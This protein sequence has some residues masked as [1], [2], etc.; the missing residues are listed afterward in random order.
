MIVI[1]LLVKASVLFAAAA[2]LQWTAA[3]RASAA[4]RHLIYTM[5]IAGVLLLPALAA[6]LPSWTALELRRATVPR[7]TQT[8]TL[9]LPR[10][11]DAVEAAPAALSGAS[12]ADPSINPPG[13]PA[14]SGPTVTFA[15]YVVVMV[16]LL[17]RL[18][19][20]R[21]SM[22]RV[23]R[24]ATIVCDAEWVHG[25]DEC[26]SMMGVRRPVQM[27]R[28]LDRTMPMTF[29]VWDAT[30]LVPAVADTWTVGRRRAV[31]LHELAHIA[32]HD[33]LTQTLA[34]I[35]CA[36]YW[37]HPG[38]WWVATRLRIE[39]EGACDDRVVAAG[40]NAREYAGHL[41]DL[42]YTLSVGTAPALAVAMASS[43]QL[44]RRLM[45]VMDAARNRALP[46]LRS[47][48]AAVAVLGAVLLPLAAATTAVVPSTEARGP[49]LASQSA[50][51]SSDGAAGQSDL[52]AG[53][54]EVRPSKELG[55]VHVQVRDRNSSYGTTVDVALINAVAPG[56]LGREGPVAF[57]IRRDAG[58]FAFEGIMRKGVGAGTF[59]FT[60]APTFASELA[61]RGFG[62]PTALQ[63]RRLAGADI[64][65]AYLDELTRQEYRK[66]DLDELVRTGE[67]DVNLTYLRDMGQLG[68]RLGQLDRLIKMRDHDVSPQYVRGLA[69]QKLRGLSAEDL[70]RAR[71]HDV[72]PD[73]IGGL[74]AQGYASTDLDVLI[75]LRSHDVSAEYVR[76]LAAYGFRGIPLDTLVRLRNHD[77]SAAYVSGLSS[78]GYQR[79]AAEALIRL[80]SHDVQ[81]E[82]V[83][84]L[85]ALG[86][87]S[88]GVDDLVA[89]RSHDVNAD[90]IRRANVRAG[91]QLPVARLTALAS[92]GWRDTR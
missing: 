36:V 63:Q 30:I 13:G 82:Y 87:S 45:A 12:M 28:S 89:L 62:R 19:I 55:R 46:A 5:A 7:P 61:K 75:R 51:R 68:Y 58:T 49:A 92:R 91:R 8:H 86:Y 37:I 48:V 85:Q 84:A 41:L 52:D 80:R 70:I 14:L 53:T 90:E 72:S 42:A 18:G 9:D 54:W 3:R 78:L 23:A 77:V 21:V 69:A 57:T 31:L 81:P 32:R 47:R 64:G 22:R 17:A 76:G 40:E 66:P 25:L 29:G 39:R 71:S 11:R 38:A 33:C 59:S 74:A 79:L 4:T 34:S 88:L 6:V 50:G 35:A 43:T 65:F 2:C 10:G 56:Q 27:L 20:D 1:S 60:P 24:V 44:E 26:K 15:A 16:L 73:Y 67:H 83:R